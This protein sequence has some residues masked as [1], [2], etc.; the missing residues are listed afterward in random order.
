MT[1][2]AGFLRTGQ[3][4]NGLS[5][6]VRQKRLQGAPQVDLPGELHDDPDRC[7]QDDALAGSD[8]SARV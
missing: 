5:L 7:W 6:A 1:R 8:R 3:F 2:S 4:D